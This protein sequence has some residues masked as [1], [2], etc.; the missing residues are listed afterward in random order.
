MF[1]ITKTSNAQLKVRRFCY[2]NKLSFALA[3]HAPELDVSDLVFYFI[4]G[5][6]TI[7]TIRFPIAPLYNVNELWI[8]FS[9]EVKDANLY[10][11]RVFDTYS[12]T[13]I[14]PF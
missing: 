1:R 4:H 3:D 9:E 8:D 6:T 13:L 10:T 2:S 7:E 12:Y 5:D 14:N 11:M